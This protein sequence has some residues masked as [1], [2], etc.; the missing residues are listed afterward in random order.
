MGMPD[1]MFG[2]DVKGSGNWRLPEVSVAANREVLQSAWRAY[3][4][5]YY[6]LDRDRSVTSLRRKAIESALGKIDEGINAAAVDGRLASPHFTD[7][8]L[9]FSYELFEFETVARI[10]DDLSQLWPVSADNALEAIKHEL[11]ASGYLR[12]VGGLSQDVLD[13]V[14][15]VVPLWIEG[16]ELG[17]LTED[18]MATVSQSLNDVRAAILGSR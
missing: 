11:R 17:E 15:G 4:R 1:T 7:P 3:D 12:S 8:A 14:D 16:L 10:L 9:Q 5:V 6:L 13:L 2:Y 18:D